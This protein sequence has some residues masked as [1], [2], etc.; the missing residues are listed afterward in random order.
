VDLIEPE[1][2]FWF[3][4]GISL[5][6]LEALVAFTLIAGPVGGAAF[7]AAIVAAL[8]YGPEAQLS[9]FIV[10]AL[11]SLLVLRPIMRRQLNQ[12]PE[13]LTN[14]DALIG[15]RAV[16]LEEVTIDQGQ[17]KIGDSV[18]SARSQSEEE[19]IAKGQRATVASLR[20]VHAII[21]V[22]AKNESSTNAVTNDTR[23]EGK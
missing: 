8:D 22:D 19:T 14:R 1:W 18:W 12:A 2:L 3:L 15:K 6:I 7:V 16:V 5:L 9:A 17:V 11:A 10:A 20:G 23:G 4:L 13:L 21:E